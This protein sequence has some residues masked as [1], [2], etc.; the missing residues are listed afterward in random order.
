[1]EKN[2]KTLN[3]QQIKNK[4]FT[5]RG[6][7]VML[8][9]DLAELYNVETRV[10]KQSVKRN[11]NRFPPDFLFKIS[12]KEI[13]LLVSQSVI[14]SKKYFGGSI[15]FAFTEQGV[16]MLASILKSSFAVKINIMI[17]RTFIQMR[18]TISNNMLIYQRMDKIE[19]KLLITDSKLEKVFQELESKDINPKQGIF[20]NGQIFDA[21]IFVSKLIKKAKKS[22][23]LIDNY[24][25]D[26]VLTLLTKRSDNCTAI[27]YTKKITDE[28]KLDLK[29]H[30]SQYS[31]ITIKELNISHDRFLILD[32]KEIYHIGSSLKDLGS[33]IFA[34]SKMEK[35]NLKILDKL[36]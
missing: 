21:Y 4:I 22:I 1:M 26:T 30:N 35:E 29:K 24:I 31:K 23:I 34:F 11:I 28:V 10:L 17:M 7:Q 8:D 16:A 33:K 6:V 19:Q 13:E 36:K 14:P 9:R 5:I 25:D 27:I 20:Y 15:P 2:I 18:K 12:E 32:K 3:D